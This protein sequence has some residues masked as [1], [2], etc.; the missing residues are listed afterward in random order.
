MPLLPL[1]GHAGVKQRLH[2]AVV[3]GTLPSSLLLQGPRGIGKQQL[4]LWLGRALICENANSALR[5]CGQCKTCKMSLELQHPDLQWFFP[6]P[7]LKDSDPDPADIRQDLAEGMSE[8]LENNGLYDAPPGDQSIFVA[9]IRALV[10]SA[11]ISPAMAKRKVFIVGDADRM[12]AQEGADQAANAFLKLLEEPPADTTILLTSSEPGA[13]L[14]TIRSRVVAVRIPPLADE[15]VRAFLADPTVAN[16]LDTGTG[17]TGE[18]IRL[19]GGAPGRL[20]G[21]EAWQAS[22]AQANRILDAATAPDRGARMRTA[23]GQ[24]ASGARGKFSDTLEALTVL[25]HQRARS[26]ST[27]GDEAGALGAAKA[28]DAVEHAKEQAYGNVNPQLVTASLLR[29]ITPLVK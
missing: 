18:L 24:G 12:V 7:R 15:E 20:I 22:I 10:Q 8:R 3:R 21:R 4:A 23:L 5:P 26:A 28:I 29:R 14:P 27:R 13:L 16:A 6:R 11:G 17:D 25:L 2:D 19:A 1:Y 9:T